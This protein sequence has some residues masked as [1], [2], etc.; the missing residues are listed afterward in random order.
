MNLLE[1]KYNWKA[2]VVSGDIPHGDMPGDKIEIREEHIQK[3]TKIFP[4]LLEQLLPVFEAEE[5]PRAVITVCGGSGVGK[6]EIASLLSWYFT[7][8]GIGSYT[9]SGDNY[10]HRIPQYND[11]ERLRIFREKGLRAMTVKNLLDPERMEQIRKWQKEGTDADSAHGEIYNWYQTYLRGGREG[12]AEYLGT[13]REIDFQEVEE[14]VRQFKTGSQN[15]WLRRMG[16]TDTDLWYEKKDFSNVQ[17]LIIEWT[18]GNSGCYQ[19]VDIPILL[20]STPQETLEHRRTRNRDGAVD[21]PFTMMVLELEQELLKR[22]AYKAKM[23]VSKK[24][25]LLTYEEYEKQMGK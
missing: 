17:V 11:A 12:L 24:G 19:G 21:S 4:E 25:E 5:S 13:S 7:Q 18:H 10:P 2:P 15:I 8:A 9:L 14:I 22:Q 6:S 20:N 23:I 16:R 3:A 1:I